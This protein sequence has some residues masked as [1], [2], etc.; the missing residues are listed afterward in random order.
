[1]KK[2]DVVIKVNPQ[3]RKVYFNDNFLGLNAE[4]LQS[5]LVFEFDGEFVNGSPRVEVEKDGNKYIIT[6]V[7]RVL[8]T[9]VMEIKSS[10]LTTDVIWFQLVITE[11]GDSEIPI[12]KSNKFFLTVGESINASTEIPDEYQTLYD[13]IE[14]KIAEVENLNVTGE[15]VSDGVEITF[16]D[17][18][19]NETTEK[20][21]D[22]AKGDTG[23][24]GPQGPKGDTG[25]TGP[26]GPQ[27]IQGEQGPQGDDYV[28][29]QQDYET[30][31]DIVETDIIP[32]LETKADK[33]E[34]Q[35]VLLQL[36]NYE[37]LPQRRCYTRLFHQSHSFIVLYSAFLLIR[38]NANNQKTRLQPDG[39]CLPCTYSM[40]ETAGC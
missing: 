26:Q 9:Y 32:I 27:G 11:A 28:I 1:M 30:I 38:P 8:D 23:E 31:A 4:N 16:T 7:T 15:R 35:K 18:L 37:I 20:V 25:A 14:E 3:D 29:T 22:G 12:F 19:G 2:N 17:K 36:T 13:Q 39:L 33:T 34:I 6:D 24:T 10:L 21:N 40:Q 5:N